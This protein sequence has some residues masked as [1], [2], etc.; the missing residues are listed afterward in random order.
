MKKIK[1][2]K[3]FCEPKENKNLQEIS[4]VLVSLSLLKLLLQLTWW[5]ID[6]CV[7]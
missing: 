6:G 2:N 1:I 3:Q 5:G 4:L 7:Y